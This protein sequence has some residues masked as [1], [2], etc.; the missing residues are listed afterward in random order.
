MGADFEVSFFLFFLRRE[1]GICIRYAFIIF[2]FVF[3]FWVLVV[4]IETSVTWIRF[5]FVFD[6]I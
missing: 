6:D 3:N 4:K 2:N 1:Y 5:C